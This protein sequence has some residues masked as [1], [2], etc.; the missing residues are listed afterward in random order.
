MRGVAFASS[1]KV[2]CGRLMLSGGRQGLHGSRLGCPGPGGGPVSFRLFL[3]ELCIRTSPL[4]R[5]TGGAAL[6]L[7]TPNSEEHGLGRHDC[8]GSH[9][10][11]I[12]IWAAYAPN[13]WITLAETIPPSSNAPYYISKLGRMRRITL[14][15]MNPPSSLLSLKTS[16][17]RQACTRPWTP[18]NRYSMTQTSSY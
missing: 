5:I 12:S 4:P 14:A 8:L 18:I 1:V 13:L 15:E 17:D 7:S 6:S 11:L 3:F 10:F 9:V 16:K 2:Q